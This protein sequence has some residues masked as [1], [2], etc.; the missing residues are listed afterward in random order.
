MSTGKPVQAGTRFGLWTTLHEVPAHIRKSGKRKRAFLVRCDCGTKREIPLIT[1]RGGLVKS[2]GCMTRE[3]LRAGSTTHG[4]T[5]HPLYKVLRHIISRCERPKHASYRNY[6]GRGIRVSPEWRGRGG[7]TAFVAWAEANG[8]RKGLDI[9]RID[10]DGDY[11]PTNCRWVT[12][13]A[14]CDNTRRTIIVEYKG[15][16]MPFKRC[17]EKYGD[18]VAYITALGRYHN[19]LPIEDVMKAP[20]CRHRDPASSSLPAVRP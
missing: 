14:N 9:D 18:G 1:L 20:K 8:Y 19:G 17:W 2:C 15:E 6:G 7:V 4:L 12:R 16:Q 3:W 5:K 11:G 10:N 13:A